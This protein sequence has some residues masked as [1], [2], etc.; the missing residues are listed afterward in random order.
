MCQIR[1]SRFSSL[2]Q[3]REQARENLETEQNIQLMTEKKTLMAESNEKIA[4]K[5]NILRTDVNE[6]EGKRILTSSMFF[7][8]VTK[9]AY[10]K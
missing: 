4:K 3:I 1:D 2:N 5:A 8:I 6:V 7:L 9:A 10:L